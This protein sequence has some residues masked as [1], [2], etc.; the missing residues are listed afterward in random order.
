MK[1]VAVRDFFSPEFRSA[2]AKGMEYTIKANNHALRQAAEGWF[3]DGL[4]RY[5]EGADLPHSK[6]SGVGLVRDAAAEK[7]PPVTIWTRI[8]S[9]L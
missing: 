8:K 1:F 3:A 5:A 7:K 9:W 6:V 2:Y 4:I